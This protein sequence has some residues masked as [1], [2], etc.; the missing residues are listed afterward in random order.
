MTP[1][2]VTLL[3]LAVVLAV[4]VG[5]WAANVLLRAAETRR[6]V[7]RGGGDESR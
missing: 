5:A 4:F 2:V 7:T 1:L 3:G 6:R